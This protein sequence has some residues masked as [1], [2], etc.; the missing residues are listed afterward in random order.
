[1][2][3]KHFPYAQAV[4]IDAMGGDFAPDICVK[5]TKQAIECGLGPV[6]LVGD[7]EQVRISILKQGFTDF[8]EQASQ[9]QSYLQIH[10][11]EQITMDDSPIKVL[12]SKKNSSIH[13][14]YQILQKEK[15]LAFLS[16]GNSGAIFSVG[17]SILKRLNSCDRPVLAGFLPTVSQEKMIL[18]D[19]GLNV[20]AK[21][22]HLFEFAL[23]GSVFAKISLNR[24]MPRVAL[25]SNGTETSKG[26]SVTK[27]AYQLIQNHLK[28][29]PHQ[30]EFIGY[31]EGRDLP[32]NRCDV[33]V[34]D[35]FVGNIVL[36]LSEGIVKAVFQKIKDQLTSSLWTKLKAYLLKK[37]LLALKSEIDWQEIGAAPILG[38][39]GLVFVSHG[40]SE[41]KAIFHAIKQIRQLEN[42]N[43]LQTLDLALSNAKQSK[44]IHLDH[45]PK[46]KPQENLQNTENR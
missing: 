17:L 19:L 4:I 13:I 3:Q 21:A 44:P 32:F 24:S 39:N 35:G 42:Q 27:E 43:L 46:E 33:V 31:L 29:H 38:L 40:A 8:F 20:E 9:N 45:E 37:P 15:A 25:L 10:A 12:K 16:A 22:E 5:A 30:F 34:C 23:I 18:L 7:T 41:S 11:D 1:M 36:K 2:D 6:I 26:T 14:A 28:N